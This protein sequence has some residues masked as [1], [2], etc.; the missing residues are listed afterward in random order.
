MTQTII[1]TGDPVLRELARPVDKVEILSAPMQCLIQAMKETMWAAPGVGLA[2]PQ[3]GES[4]Q[5]IVIEDKKEYHQGATQEQ[6]QAR[7]R[8][9]VPLHVII[10]PV[11]TIESAEYV[12]FYE[13]C[14]SVKDFVGMVPR[15]RNVKVEG[16]NEKGEPIT[17]RAYG[18]YAR[19][20]QHEFDHLQGML[21]VDRMDTRTFSTM[22]NYFMNCP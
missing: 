6:L 10:N 20:L 12:Q 8:F 11:L 5:I 14:L 7:E 16:L 4:L 15:A 22:E 2:A 17:I 3:I 19:I 9:P 18:W 13:G 21:Y 1:Q